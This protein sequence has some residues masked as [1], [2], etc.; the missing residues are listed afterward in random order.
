[1]TKPG[2]KRG[3]LFTDVGSLKAATL[4]Y[5]TDTFEAWIRERTP[6][7]DDSAPGPFD[8][9]RAL[10]PATIE[11]GSRCQVRTGDGSLPSRYCESHLHLDNEPDN[12]G[13]Q[14][15]L[16]AEELRGLALEE[17]ELQAFAERQARDVEEAR[18]HPEPLTDVE[19]LEKKAGLEATEDEAYRLLKN[20]RDAIAALVSFSDSSALYT[21]V[22]ETRYQRHFESFAVGQAHIFTIDFGRPALESSQLN[23]EWSMPSPRAMTVGVAERVFAPFEAHMPRKVLTCFSLSRGNWPEKKVLELLSAAKGKGISVADVIDAESRALDNHDKKRPKR[24]TK[25]KLP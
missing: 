24:R 10:C 4:Q 23:L 20:V 14:R 2:P 6:F 9:L 11:G 3:E 17:L 13:G 25:P 15:A 8:D 7:I 19:W 22:E 18:R 21:V 16:T 12:D 5:A 1:M